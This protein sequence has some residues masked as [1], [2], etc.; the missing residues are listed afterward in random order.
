MNRGWGVCDSV[1]GSAGLKD[2]VVFWPRGM[3]PD[4]GMTVYPGGGS[5]FK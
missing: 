3:R 2:G 5:K 4:I 1:D